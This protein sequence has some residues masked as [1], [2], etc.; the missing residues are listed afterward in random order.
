MFVTRNQISIGKQFDKLLLEG[1]FDLTFCTF[2]NLH[3]ILFPKSMTDFYANFGSGS[4]ITGSVVTLISIIEVVIFLPFKVIY[5]AFRYFNL[6]GD[7]EKR[8]IEQSPFFV[9]N[10]MKSFTGMIYEAIFMIR[11]SIT[12]FV[13]M[14]LMDYPIFQMQVIILMSFFNVTYMLDQKPLLGQKSYYYNEA[15]TLV[16]I[17]LIYVLLNISLD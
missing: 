8:I 4:D 7:E 3:L 9:Q 5:K 2:I 15:F 13:I 14:Y 1:S 12:L 6:A 16:V 11:R 10:K 17:D